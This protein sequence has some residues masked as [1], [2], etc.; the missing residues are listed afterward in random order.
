VLF[1]LAVVQL[2][3]SVADSHT[4][5]A[6]GVVVGDQ[7]GDVINVL[8]GHLDQV[9]G[10]MFTKAAAGSPHTRGTPGRGKGVRFARRE[11]RVRLAPE[12]YGELPAACLAEEIETPGPGQVRAQITIAGNPVLSTPNGARLARALSSL[13]LMVSLDIYVNETSRFADVVLPGLSPL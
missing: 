9:G 5:D 10:A 3:L 8:T 12:I 4:V 1:L 2:V 6:A 11:S 7:R 13:E